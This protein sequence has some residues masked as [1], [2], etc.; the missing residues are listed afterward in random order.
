MFV[1]EREKDTAVRVWCALWR[2]SSGTFKVFKRVS[3]VNRGVKF[4]PGKRVSGVD[5]EG[6]VMGCR[7]SELGFLTSQ[8]GG[9]GGGGQI[10]GTGY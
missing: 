10:G 4:D 3:W 9:L 2:R 1:L 8:E 6:R 5:R 7:C